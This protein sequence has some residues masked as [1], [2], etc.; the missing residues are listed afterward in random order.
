MGESAQSSCGP[1]PEEG[2]D[3]FM[4]AAEYQRTESLVDCSEHSPALPPSHPFRDV[5]EGYWSSTTSMFEPD[6][7]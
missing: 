4:A 2:S 5:R 7:A 6:W 3:L 1:E